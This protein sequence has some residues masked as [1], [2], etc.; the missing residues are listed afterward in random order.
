MLS[1]LNEHAMN[2]ELPLTSSTPVGPIIE[3]ALEHLSAA[4]FAEL[5]AMLDALRTQSAATPRWEFCEG[6]M[7]ALICSRR[8]MTA[9]EYLPVLLAVP[10]AN[11]AQQ[12]DFMAL[13]TRR[14]H[15]VAQALDAKITALD[16]A[17]AYQPEVSDP[18]AAQAGA[19]A[20][21]FGQQWALGFM[22][23][24]AAWPAEWA[25]SRNKEAVKWRT[26][27]LGFVAALTQDD[28][29]APTLHA[30]EDAQ[31]APTVSVARMKAFGD[32]IWAV[33]NMREMWR[34]LGPRIET[35]VKTATPGR[36]DPCP[37]GS[38]KKYK[39]CCGLLLN[40]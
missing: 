31:G 11:A 30:F 37:C 13:W 20:A 3:S 40:E 9:E 27:A 24:V 18:Q 19:K 25:G 32:A 26:A 5:D 14:W 1:G 15:Q 21:S 2:P 33:Y 34:N 6:F 23:V 38:A 16:E 10:F 4:E 36:N 29:D 8:P 12:E 22:A 35:V 39:K 17:S 28:R 7:A